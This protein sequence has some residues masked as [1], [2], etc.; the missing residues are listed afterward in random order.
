[1]MAISRADAALSELAGVGRLM[2]NPHLF[3]AP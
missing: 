3:I 1:V 2:P